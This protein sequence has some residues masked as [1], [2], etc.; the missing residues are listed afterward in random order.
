MRPTPEGVGN[1][2]NTNDR[3]NWMIAS[4]RPTPEG[5]GNNCVFN[6]TLFKGGGFNEAHARRRGK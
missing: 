1:A 3:E 2:F 6:D 4:M 5:V